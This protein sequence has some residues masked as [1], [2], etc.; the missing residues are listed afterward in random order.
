M[1]P[2]KRATDGFSGPMM[3]PVPFRGSV[4]AESIVQLP[5]IE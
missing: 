1:K 3:A 2:R 5:E 4:L